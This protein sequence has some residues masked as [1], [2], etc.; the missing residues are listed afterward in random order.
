[1]S[2]TYDITPNEAA[3]TQS[4]QARAAAA[5]LGAA[6][7]AKAKHVTG[8]IGELEVL[9]FNLVIE[10]GKQFN[11]ACGREQLLFTVDGAEFARREILPHLDPGLT[12]EHVKCAV[13]LA[14]THPEPLKSIEELKSVKREF[15]QILIAFNIAD[16]PGRRELQTAHA[17]NLF[18]DLVNWFTTGPQLLS[19][20]EAAEPMDRWPREKLQ[21]FVE[22][23]KPLKERIAKAEKLLLGVN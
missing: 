20:L 17:R 2:E 7:L 16:K 22:E 8:N 13:K 5:K 21:E 11:I 23:A 12:L 19:K 9:C 1:M 18:A 4:R 6:R 10:A 14:V 15:Q 3:L